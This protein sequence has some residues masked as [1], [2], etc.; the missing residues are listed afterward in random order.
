M[1]PLDLKKYVLADLSVLQSAHPEHEIA[2]LDL[3]PLQGVETAYEATGNIACA[4]IWARVQA[5]L[6]DRNMHFQADTWGGGSPGGGA[7]FGHIYTDNVDELLQNTSKVLVYACAAY[8][9]FVFQNR[10]ERVLG[11]F[12]AGSVST[13]AGFFKGDGRWHD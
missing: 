2:K 8:T 12:Q 5:R 9:A 6:I 11:H 10:V 4:V 7:L 1:Q 3:S 13:V